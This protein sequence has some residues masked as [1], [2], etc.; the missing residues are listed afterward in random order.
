MSCSAEYCINGTFSAITPYNGTYYSAGTYNTKI[1]WSGLTAGFVYFDTTKW[2]LSSSLG[3]SCVAFGS[4]P[5]TSD[6]PDLS[7]TYFSSGVC[8]ITPTPTPTVTTTNTP[9]T[10]PTPTTTIT[11]T[12]TTTPTLTPTMTASGNL[13]SLFGVVLNVVQTTTATPTPTPTK[14]PTPTPVTFAPVYGDVTYTINEINFSSPISRKLLDCV[15]GTFQ[16]TQSLLNYS[17]GTVSTGQT[18]TCV[19]GGQNRCFTYLTN[20]V[21]STTVVISSVNEVI[22]SCDFCQ[23]LSPTPTPTMTPTPSSTPIPSCNPI[24]NGLFES[25]V[26]CGGACTGSNCSAPTGYRLYP[27][28]CVPGWSTTASDSSIE[29]WKTGF[30]GYSAFSGSYFTE[31]Q[32]TFSEFQAVYQTIIV[33]P[34]ASYQISFAHMGRSGFSNTLKV[35]LSGATDGI[36]VIG[37]P[38]YSATSGSWT[39]HTITHTFNPTDTVYNLFFSGATATNGGNFLDNIIMSCS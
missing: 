25:F 24:V 32:G 11:S 20:E 23:P 34:S 3:G 26:T 35:V 38:T 15:S 21:S 37:N 10:T 27:Q 9:T 7:N 1:Y 36:E 31:V 2:C 6:C 39:S 14:T 16:Y 28:E 29:I 22:A 18:F 12:P 13:C 8:S 17:G 33:Q 5:S 19:V 4:E 30:G